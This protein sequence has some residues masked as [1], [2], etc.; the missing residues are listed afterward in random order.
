MNRLLSE[1][2]R[3][4]H[5]RLDFNQ[6]SP[7]MVR[8]LRDALAVCPIGRIALARRAGVNHYSLYAMVIGR[9]ATSKD[10]AVKVA[11][12]LLALSPSPSGDEL[13]AIELSEPVTLSTHTAL[14]QYE[15]AA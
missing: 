2:A 12:A 5:V 9:H 10:V 6:A 13:L 1:A 15:N 8:W 4:E 11:R 14:D 3:F 7:G